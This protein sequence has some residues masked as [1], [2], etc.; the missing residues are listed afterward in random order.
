MK[1]FV[2]IKIIDD[3]KISEITE[4]LKKCPLHKQ[5]IGDCVRIDDDKNGFHIFYSGVSK[6]GVIKILKYTSQSNFKI[7]VHITENVN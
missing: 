7:S 3:I 5:I 6:N 2:S 1:Y 4:F